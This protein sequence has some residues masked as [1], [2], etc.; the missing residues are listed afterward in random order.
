MF[1][2]MESREITLVIP[3]SSIIPVDKTRM[4]QEYHITSPPGS[5]RSKRSIEASQSVAFANSI[6]RSA[7]PS[8]QSTPV[9]PLSYP[10]ARVT[11]VDTIRAK[12]ES[13]ETEIKIKEEIFNKITEELQTA[14][15]KKVSDNLRQVKL[16]QIGSLAKSIEQLRDEINHFHE[17]ERIVLQD[18]KESAAAQREKGGDMILWR[19]NSVEA[20][21]LLNAGDLYFVNRER[22]VKQLFTIHQETYNRACKQRGREWEVALCANDYGAGKSTFADM[23]VSLLRQFPPEKSGSEV[24]SRLQNAVTIHISLNFPQQ[25]R[26]EVLPS[27]ML[28]LIKR[29]ISRKVSRDIDFSTLPDSLLDFMKELVSRSDR[30]IFLVIDE[31][32]KPFIKSFDSSEKIQKDQLTDFKHF[33]GI[34]ISGLLEIEGLFLLLC[35]R[36]PFLDWVGTRPND[37][38]LVCLASPLKAKRIVLNMIRPDRIVEIL[39]NTLFE[40]QDKEKT[41]LSQFLN[42]EGP[43]NV[44]CEEYAERLYQICAGHPRTIAEILFE[45]C[46]KID[47]LK[48][49]HGSRPG[50][51]TENEGNLSSSALELLEET[52]LKFSKSTQRLLKQCGKDKAD[53]DLTRQVGGFT[54]EHLLPPLRIGVKE[55]EDGSIQL[56]VPD[57]IRLLLEALVSPLFDYINIF[58]SLK[59]V[60]INFS[61]AFEILVAKV[62]NHWFAP[63][64]MDD[65]VKDQTNES[66]PS[67]KNSSIQEGQVGRSNGLKP[68]EI[69]GLFFNTPIF[70]NWECFVSENNVKKFPKVT[71]ATEK[72]ETVWTVSLKKAKDQVKE[73]FDAIETNGLWLLPNPMSSSPDLIHI[74]DSNKGKRILCIAV[75]NYSA[76]SFLG[77]S[78][79]LKEIIKAERMIPDKTYCSVLVI[80]CTNYTKQI[81]RGFNGNGFQI[82]PVSKKERGKLLEVILLNLTT[83]ELRAKFCGEDRPMGIAGLEIL[84]NKTQVFAT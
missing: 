77:E 7:N 12:I 44:L 74:S 46:K 54:Y 69:C 51:V 71:S 22:A 42:L 4:S 80:A 38:S 59:T 28:A 67:S 31:V 25:D 57:R 68:K 10:S 45:R 66:I 82:F 29:E 24:L 81:V 32:A 60:P 8:L 64:T 52:A 39:R 56:R 23:Y 62:F 53:F 76:G 48:I 27:R 55:F 72:N 63:R 14:T 26:T 49:Q 58:E 40:S 15:K 17:K 9:T 18:A 33:T 2:I 21:P 50:L 20:N 16:I 75:K 37:R 47:A 5:G 73:N 79:I 3:C 70:G 65:S 34:T 36:A 30:A 43:N 35:G 83:S 78:D 41:T 6:Q 11:E 61:F 19:E 1:Y 13:K 84:V